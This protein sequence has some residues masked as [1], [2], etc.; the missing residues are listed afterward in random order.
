MTGTGVGRQSWALVIATYD[1]AEILGH[2]IRLAV[3]Q[4]RPPAE[5]IVTDAGANW[6]ETG[7]AIRRE[8]LARHPGIAFAYQPAAE[9]S[10]TVQRNQGVGLTRSDVLFLIDDDSLMHPGCAAEI[11]AIYE[12]D[13]A[14][15]IAGVQANL[16]DDLPPGLVIQGE[17]KAVGA[18]KLGPGGGPSALLALRDWLRRKVFL[19]DAGELFIPYDGAAHQAPP[20]LRMPEGAE[21]TYLFHG[22]RMTFRREAVVR[23]PFEPILRSYCPGEDLDASYRISRAW[24]AGHRAP[25]HAAPLSE[26]RRPDQ[27]LPGHAAVGAEPGRL[28]PPAFSG[29]GR[30]AR[31]VRQP[32]AAASPRGVPQ[33]SPQPPVEPAADARPA[34]GPALDRRHLRHVRRRT[35]ELVSRHAAANPVAPAVTFAA[36][37]AATPSSAASRRPVSA[38]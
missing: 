6:R 38:Q 17:R 4:S 19:M 32:D 25:R 1:R 35:G 30:A 13:T 33:G 24:G 26:R 15:D 27:P 34:G 18:S 22:C 23:E 36:C 21:R 8:V 12:A 3:E 31:G 5:V 20:A 7:E 10:L 16:S 14:G 37:A 11:M 29:P 28:H 2:C 9:K